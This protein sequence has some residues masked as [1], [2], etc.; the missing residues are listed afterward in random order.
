MTPTRRIFLLRQY[1]FRAEEIPTGPDGHLD[2][3]RD[4][5]E[6]WAI[7]HP[8]LFPLDPNRASK[9]EL[10]RVPGLGPL[11]VK[12]LLDAR[13]HCTI[14]QLTGVLPEHANTRKAR[15]YLKVA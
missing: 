13:R 1:G 7:A 11:A 8:E 12:R 3:T 10:L 15:P 6:S 5:K 14:R 9:E 4:P 2:L